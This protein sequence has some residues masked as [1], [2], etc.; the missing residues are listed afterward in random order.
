MIDADLIEAAKTITDSL[1]FNRMLGLRVRSFRVGEVTVVFDMQPG[2]VGNTARGVLHGG[3]ISASLDLVG[4][5][6]ALSQI[7]KDREVADV[8]DVGRVFSKFGT[9]DLRIDYLRPGVG[10]SFSATGRVLRAGSRVA[11]TRMELHNDTDD[12]IAVGTGTYSV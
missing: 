11:V 9:I 8:D 2:L 12:L 4:G 5:A 7:L 10:K 6:T 3:V 1:P